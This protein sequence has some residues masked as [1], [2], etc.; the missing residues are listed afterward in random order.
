MFEKVRQVIADQLGI[1]DTDKITMGT[2]LVE[3]LEADS[4]D[5]VEIVMALED[6]FDL[7]IAD[8]QAENFKTVKQ[9]CDY[10]E[11]NA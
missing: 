8:E 10:I 1:D 5:A 3:D 11:E 7:E 9:I 4:L 6:E 2:S